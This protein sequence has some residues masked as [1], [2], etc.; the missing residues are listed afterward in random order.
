MCENEALYQHIVYDGTPFV[1]YCKL[2]WQDL[3]KYQKKRS[4]LDIQLPVRSPVRRKVSESPALTEGA[5][6]ESSSS[7]RVASESSNSSRSYQQIFKSRRKIVPKLKMH[8]D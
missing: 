8:S 5:A 6:S 1:E 7:S 3:M 4:A 2:Y